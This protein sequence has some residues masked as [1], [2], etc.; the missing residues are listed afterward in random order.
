M[1]MR[2]PEQIVPLDRIDS[3]DTTYRITTR[4]G[5]AD[6]TASII[7]LGVVHAPI[8]Q[9]RG[10][11]WIIVAGFR[12]IAVCRE[13][14]LT[15]IAAKLLPSEATEQQ[16][17]ELAITDNTLQRPLNLIETAR[18]LE[19]LS[20]CHD[21]TEQL[22]KAAM[23]L[24]LPG[25]PD[26]VS[27]L[28]RLATL[29]PTIQGAVLDEVVTLSMALTLADLEEPIADEWVRIFRDL[30]VGLNRQ[31]ELLT[32]VTEIALREEQSTA[33]VLFDTPI[34]QFLSPSSDD[35]TAAQKYRLLAATLRRR[36]F[37][38]IA[39]AE[40]RFQDLLQTL[41]LGPQAQLIPPTHFEGT[42]Y[43]LR[44]LF[45]N[46]EELQRHLQTIEELSQHSAFKDFLE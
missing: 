18:S 20:R 45:R 1:N 4:S 22:I 34:R 27:K 8:L 41:P 3:E 5:T 11:Q 32:L 42:D 33:A 44:L 39:R 15:E 29:S 28:L 35:M 7:G 46:L 9:P 25:S 2:L 38:N 17:I 24:N 31:R 30:N 23:R 10:K 37:P 12:R 36:R 13:I 14:Q 6:L 26:H 43:Q 21:S 16:R 40:R 19:M